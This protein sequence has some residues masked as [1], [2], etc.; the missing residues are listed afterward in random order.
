MKTFS[1]AIGVPLSIMA[2]NITMKMDSR[3]I[4]QLINATIVAIIILAIVAPVGLY[5]LAW[6]RDRRRMEEMSTPRRLPSQAQQSWGQPGNQS[7]NQQ[8]PMLTAQPM[9]QMGTFSVEQPMMGHQ[10]DWS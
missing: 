7:W 8:P 5:V 9:P 4:D 1:M 6:L 2:Y 10:E 3:N